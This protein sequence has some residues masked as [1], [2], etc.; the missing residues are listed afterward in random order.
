MS[1]FAF[2]TLALFAPCLRFNALP[3]SRFFIF[4]FF[5]LPQNQRAFFAVR[6]G[7]PRANCPEYFYV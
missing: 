5:R 7:E 2:S 1:R 4:Q 3:L 6:A